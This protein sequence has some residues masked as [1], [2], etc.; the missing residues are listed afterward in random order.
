MCFQ[1]RTRLD[2]N[3]GVIRT[4]EDSD[5]GDINSGTRKVDMNAKV[6]LGEG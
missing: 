4:E 5:E 3:Y 1:S 2:R 6:D